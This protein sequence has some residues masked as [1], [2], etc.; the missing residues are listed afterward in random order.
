MADEQ[1][2]TSLRGGVDELV[3]SL[4]ELEAIDRKRA[5]LKKETEKMI[6]DGTEDS[7]RWRV[8]VRRDKKL[9]EESTRLRG[10]MT[11]T[12]EQMTDEIDSTWTSEEEVSDDDE[13][14]NDAWVQGA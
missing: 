6:R 5:V 11:W 3:S 8:C 10:E 14:E 12:L 9:L 7:E 1:L 2:M 13:Y 4:E